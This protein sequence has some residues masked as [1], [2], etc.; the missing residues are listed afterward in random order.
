[1]RRLRHELERMR[2]AETDLSEAMET[3]RGAR[4]RVE[5][6]LDD[7]T[8]E[9]D[10]VRA[11][12]REELWAA[13][14]GPGKGEARPSAGESPP[15]RAAASGPDASPAPREPREE[16]GEGPPA[17]TEEEDADAASSEARWPWW[18][19]AIAVAIVAAVALAAWLASREMGGDPREVTVAGDQP[20][21]AAV[22]SSEAAGDSAEADDPLTFFGRLPDDPA[23][24]AQVYDSLWQARSPLFD[25]LI[26]RID[27]ETDQGRVDM[28]ISAW[29]EGGMAPIQEDLLHTLMVQLA[30]REEVDSNLS[31][32]GT[33]LRNPCRGD[34]C[35]A[36]LNFWEV[37]SDEYVLPEMP[38][39]APRNTEAL[40]AVEAALVLGAMR[41][42]AGG[43]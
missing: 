28:A 34:S 26:R 37:G 27:E 41:R 40:R 35:S 30:L 31:L 12:V 29:R 6:L 38:D 25:P 20:G 9:S 5:E 10:R 39:D 8:R 7:L 21:P 13:G 16:T 22:P 42:A 33:L 17:T 11:L 23:V 24:R 1:M 2:Q 43:R 15:A 4:S 19:A 36:L 18:K 3:V 14:V 32:D